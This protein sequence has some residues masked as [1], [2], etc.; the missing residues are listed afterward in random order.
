MRLYP[1]I[2]MP[3]QRVVPEGGRVIAGRFYAAGTLVGMTPREIHRDP[4][5]YGKDAT[6]W[7]PDRW[8]EGNRVDLEKPNLAVRISLITVNSHF[9]LCSVVGRGNSRMF[10]EEYI[11]DGDV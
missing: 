2:D 7:H 6:E 5:A 11:S 1:A 8:L 9:L 3:L 4:R 10:G